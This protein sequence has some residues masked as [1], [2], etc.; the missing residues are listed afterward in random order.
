MAH[1]TEAG[2]STE[3]RPRGRLDRILNAIERAGNTLPDPA[4][5]FAIL[6]VLVWALSALLAPIA[7]ARSSATSTAAGW[8]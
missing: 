1:G 3:P 7:R 6:L 5:L 2:R 4:A 8:S